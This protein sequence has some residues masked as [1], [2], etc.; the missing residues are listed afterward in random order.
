[1]IM[2]R[3]LLFTVGTIGI[4]FAVY[5]LTGASSINKITSFHEKVALQ[6]NGPNGGLTG[7]PGEGTCT[8]CHGGSI[9]DGNTGMNSVILDGGAE[10]FIPGETVSVNV[11]LTDGSNKN[12]FQVVVLDQNDE[13]AGSFVITDATNTQPRT[14][15]NGQRS[16][17]T[18]TN[19][20][21]ALSS[22]EFDW[23]VPLGIE[24]AT[25]YLATNKT[26]S[27]NATSGDQVYVSSHQFTLEDASLENEIAFE[28]S[29]QITYNKD[30]NRL[31]MDFSFDKSDDLSLNI[32][33][34][35]GRSVHYERFNALA[36]GEYSEN[37]NIQTPLENG[38]Y[39]ASFFIGN[40]PI[41]KK[42]MVQ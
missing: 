11:S 21:N 33:D 4:A 40:Q 36:P 23:E 9:L 1:M 34:L 37:V 28:N 38:I 29:L 14:N 3:N 32:V 22:W 15:A 8:S 42:F 19:S 6:S 41:S 26:N 30:I 10:N 39:I 35:N 20:G 12:G 25:F 27:N 13:M 7:A 16:Y 2:K 24:E 17:V 31:V 5:T 18:H